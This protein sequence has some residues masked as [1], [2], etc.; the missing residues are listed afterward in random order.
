MRQL[1]LNWPQRSELG[2][3]SSRMLFL[4]KC[5]PNYR[6][7]RRSFI[8]KT[9][10]GYLATMLLPGLWSVQTKKKNKYAYKFKPYRQGKTRAPVLK[11]TP[12]EGFFVHS[13]YDV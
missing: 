9:S 6:M 2:L 10:A 11:V 1:K 12:D 7:N 3:R 5:K 4:R 13:F 8:S